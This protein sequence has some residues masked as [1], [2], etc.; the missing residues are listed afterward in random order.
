MRTG[1][2]MTATIVLLAIPVPATGA[3]AGTA[4]RKA[5]AEMIQ[6]VNEVR[7]K[8]GLK[9]LRRSRSLA[10]SARRFS[11]WLMEN[12]T[13]GHVGS[14]QASSHFWMLGEALAMHSGRRFRV[15]ATVERWMASPSHRALVLTDTM[16][17]LG[18]GVTRGRVRA[19][20]A[21][22]WVLHLGRLHAPG[23]LPVPQAPSLPLP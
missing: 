1:T 16:R 22:I 18:I 5:E 10:G 7:A 13:F 20:S 14:I 6:Q 23:T 2:A 21:T 19:S 17:W 12:D 4:N 8:H 9:A 11:H 3:E 15:R